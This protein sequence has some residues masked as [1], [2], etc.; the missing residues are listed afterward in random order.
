MK[1]FRLLALLATVVALLASHAFAQSP[2]IT[3]ISVKD[4][5][6]FYKVGVSTHPC[7]VAPGMTVTIAGKN[8]GKSGGGVILCD[9]SSATVVTW[10]NT[11]VVVTINAANPNASLLL[12]TVGGAFSNSVPYAAI[13]PVITSIVVGNC[14]Y[15][16]NQSQFLCMIT[17][18]TQV[19]I[20]G[21]YFGPSTGGGSVITC[22][23]GV[24]P[25]INSWNPNWLT[26]P[27]PYNNQIVIIANQAVCGSTV[28]ILFDSMWSNFVPYTAC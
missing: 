21:S 9:C 15:V 24:P 23:C 26:S 13:A 11:R 19:T 20:N 28:A 10:A 8:F 7:S 5:S 17:P 1:L 25:T 16:P 2:T 27:S 18:G 22:D 6:C 3:N 14:T 4:T 12:E